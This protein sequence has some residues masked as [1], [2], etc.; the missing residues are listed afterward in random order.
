MKKNVGML[1]LLLALAVSIPG[2]DAQFCEG[3]L[4][5]NL[6]PGDTA[7]VVADSLLNVRSEPSLSGDLLA[8]LEPDTEL[9][10]IN[11]PVCADRHAW[12]ETRLDDDRTGW[13]AEADSE[14]YWLGK[15]PRQ[16][17]TYERPADP[18]GTSPTV[19]FTYPETSIERID[20][21][22]A[23]M[24]GA[25]YSGEQIILRTVGGGPIF[26][27][28]IPFEEFQT[29]ADG[30]YDRAEVLHDLIDEWS[31]EALG[32]AYAYP[33]NQGDWPTIV[34]HKELQEF[35]NGRGF[36]YIAAYINLDELE[37]VDQ[38]S[39]WYAF[40]GLTDD[41]AYFVNVTMPIQTPQ[42]PEGP[43]PDPE[44]MTEYFAGYLPW[45]NEVRAFLLTKEGAS[46]SPMLGMINSIV[47]S[48]EIE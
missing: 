11:G 48:L 15:L 47:Y 32:W 41:G 29:G 37:P 43:T 10:V 16:Y 45:I 7:I 6:I 31:D 9:V 38:D 12:Y 34:V 26:I 5:S 28:A 3:T 18:D 39:F 1:I 24:H 19:R 25:L 17:A 8:Q 4:Y 42:L 44:D 22:S 14:E 30:G 35:Q 33:N 36:S 13:V 20:F 23:Y 27:T 21:D 2:A 46:F 40:H